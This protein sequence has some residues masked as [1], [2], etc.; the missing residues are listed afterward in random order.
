MVNISPSP[1]PSPSPS[2]PPKHDFE[3]HSFR[4]T[5]PS[6][7]A[8]VLTALTGTSLLEELNRQGLP[9]FG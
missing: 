4:A 9:F 5:P 8:L 2:S 3:W 6:F 7:Y 1:P